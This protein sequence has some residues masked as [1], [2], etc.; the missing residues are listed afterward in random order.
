MSCLCKAALM[1]F[2][3]ELPGCHDMHGWWIS[4]SCRY[5][6]WY[7]WDASM[8]RVY[9]I[10]QMLHPIVNPWIY[11][12]C[13]TLSISWWLFPIAF[14]LELWSRFW[15]L[16]HLLIM[17]PSSLVSWDGSGTMRKRGIYIIFKPL[18]YIHVWS[19]FFTI[20]AH[21]SRSRTW[22]A[23][24]KC[25]ALSDSMWEKQ[26]CRI[27]IIC[28]SFNLRCVRFCHLPCCH[29][30]CFGLIKINI[31]QFGNCTSQPFTGCVMCL[32]SSWHYHYWMFHES[33]G[34]SELSHALL[35][36]N[37]LIYMESA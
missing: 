23:E 11:A 28:H 1:T 16:I 12:Q 18:M 37:S 26:V 15:S 5:P 27:M 36:F 7:L 17:W 14:L 31:Q 20:S 24:S 6:E 10:L 3:K 9:C 32:V 35:T 4:C 25:K 30:H 8:L 34:R 13:I 33:I 22:Y 29:V 19:L 21:L 2:K